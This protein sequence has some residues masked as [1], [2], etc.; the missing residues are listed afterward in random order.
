MKRNS[1]SYRSE[2]H[3]YDRHNVGDIEMQRHKRGRTID[4]KHEQLLKLN[5]TVPEGVLAGKTVYVN[6][7]SG[8]KVK[9]IIPKGAK[10]G[11]VIS[12]TVPP[13]MPLVPNPLQRRNDTEGDSPRSDSSR[14]SDVDDS[15]DED[16]ESN[17]I[18]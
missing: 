12:V 3:I 2:D 5:F 7:P 13:E 1:F 10:A 9:V 17:L 4:G 6:S 14:S 8:H 15:S 18:I 11:Q 16:G